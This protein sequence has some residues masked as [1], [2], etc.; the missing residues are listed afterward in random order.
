M[1]C[2]AY[3]SSKM[4]VVCELSFSATTSIDELWQ[5]KNEI[6]DDLCRAEKKFADLQCSIR[7]RL[8][9]I[10]KVGTQLGGNLSST[11]FDNAAKQLDDL[12]VIQTKE[13]AE[14]EAAMIEVSRLDA[15]Y[16]AISEVLRKIG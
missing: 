9:E 6:Q 4:S 15:A 12:Q 11:E 8:V 5:K 2:G 7:K 14:A 1:I 16:N 10:Q 3:K 13:E